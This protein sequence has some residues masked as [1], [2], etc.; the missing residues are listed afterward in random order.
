MSKI[1]ARLK[2]WILS[3]VLLVLFI[4]FTLIVAFVDV[5]GVGLSHL[6]QF[7]LQHCGKHIVWE[8]IT[9][10]LGYLT[11]CGLLF[12]IC[13]QVWQWVRRKSWRMIDKNLICF[14]FVCIA[15]AM[16]YIIFEFLV[17]NY[18]PFLDNGNAEVSYPSS[19]TMLFATILPLLVYQ[20]WRYINSKPWRIALT[21]LISII[22]VVGIVGR[23]FSGL[24]WFTDVLAGLI[25]SCCLNAFYFA[26]T[27]NI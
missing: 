3:S 26:L 25:I 7:F 20:I 13:L 23:L 9:D 21:V 15:L 10:W 8:N 22:M 17:I 11:I 16:V 6:N 27:K 1:S 14:D 5:D 2:L 4:A 12:F 24:H 18:R 19:H